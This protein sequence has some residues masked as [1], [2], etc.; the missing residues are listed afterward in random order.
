MGTQDY[1]IKVE[2]GVS[3]V[4]L[5]I[6][7]FFIFQA[8]TIETSREAV[9]PRTMPMFLAIALVLGGLWLAIRALTGR[10]GDLKDGYGFL[11]SDVKRI[12]M[13][14]G[15]GVLFVFLFWG[16]GYF[17]AIIATYIAMLYT[18]GVR[19]WG[20]MVGGGLVLAFIFQWLFMGIMLLNDPA[21]AIIDMRPFTNWIT[22]A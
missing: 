8:F 3:A 11:E 10:A 21:G 12:L 6:G 17:T 14:V 13:V 19:N 16:L 4:V 5:L 1:K 15:C 9:G 18:F 2:Y 22:G 20:W 7:V